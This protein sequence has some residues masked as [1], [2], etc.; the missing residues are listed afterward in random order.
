MEG[1]GRSEGGTDGEGKH[2]N[3][4]PRVLPRQ[5][6]CSNPRERDLRPVS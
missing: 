3:H 4:A 5:T 2:G 6:V 1:K